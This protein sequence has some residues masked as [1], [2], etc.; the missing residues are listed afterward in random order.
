MQLLDGRATSEQ[1]KKELA[2]AVQDRKKNGKKIPHFSDL[3]CGNGMPC[4]C[5]Q[6][7]TAH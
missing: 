7:V 1:I 4:D 3:A 5:V 6:S 2:I